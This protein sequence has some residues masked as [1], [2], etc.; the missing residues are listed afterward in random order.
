[1]SP[2]SHIE[3][4]VIASEHNL[5]ATI[6]PFKSIRAG[7]DGSAVFV[8]F[9]EAFP[10]GFGVPLLQAVRIIDM[11][12][13]YEEGAHV[14]AGHPVLL[15]IRHAN[16]VLIQDFTAFHVRV[17]NPERR[18]VDIFIPKGVVAELNISGGQRNAVMKLDIP[19]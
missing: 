4:L 7:A 2:A 12:W 17:V 13:K 11:L 19:P 5:N 10:E 14:V 16:G 1:M 6:P 8:A 3:V 15:G 9:V 18:G